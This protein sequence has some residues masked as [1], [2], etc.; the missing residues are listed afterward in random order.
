MSVSWDSSAFDAALKQRLAR[1]E[2]SS[3]ELP[4]RMASDMADKARSTVTRRT[5]QTGGS[6]ESH[7]TAKGTAE[8]VSDNAYLEFGTSKMDAQPFI[9][10]ARAE[11]ISAYRAGRYKPEL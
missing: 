9:R 2:K 10:P 5:G 6:I 1:L 11:V 8:L 4:E 7:S 3:D